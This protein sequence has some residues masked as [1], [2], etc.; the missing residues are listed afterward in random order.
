MFTDPW[1]TDSTESPVG[2]LTP[3]P[4]KKVGGMVQADFRLSDARNTDAGGT[5]CS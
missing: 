5:T 1:N 4:I 3:R 2:R